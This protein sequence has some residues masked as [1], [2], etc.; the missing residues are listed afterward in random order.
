[1]NTKE[2]ETLDMNI[3]DFN[4]ENLL[5]EEK[6]MLEIYGNLPAENKEEF[7]PFEDLLP[8]EKETL[9][10]YKNLLPEEIQ[11]IRLYTR[12]YYDHLWRIRDDL[13]TIEFMII[14]NKIKS[15][16]N[17]TEN[18]KKIIM[19]NFKPYL[20]SILEASQDLLNYSNK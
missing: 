16:P 18:I 5:L 13:E 7:G 11:T 19:K 10:L 17:L 12:K 9:Y 20:Q 8:E 1:M 14:D 4:Q 2:T 3:K 15:N 6:E